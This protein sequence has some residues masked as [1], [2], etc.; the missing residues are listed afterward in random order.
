MCTLKKAISQKIEFHIAYNDVADSCFLYTEDIADNIMSTV[1]QNSTYKNY[2]FYLTIEGF[3]ILQQAL[4]KYKEWVKIAKENQ[5]IIGDPKLLGKEI[6]DLYIQANV[7][8]D[9]HSKAPIVGDIHNVSASPKKLSFRVISYDNETHVF[10]IFQ[11]DVSPNATNC[12]ALM[13]VEPWADDLL[14]F[15]EKNKVADTVSKLK[16]EINKKKEKQE[17]DKSLFN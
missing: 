4:I 8:L 5:A 11:G 15:L 9:I 1:V 10:T 16:A 2:K 6:P 14:A 17:K 7:V 12:L 3:D 13:F